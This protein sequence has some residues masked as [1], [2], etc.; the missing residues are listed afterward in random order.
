MTKI[1]YHLDEI[2]RLNRVGISMKS[3][4]ARYG[5][6]QTTIVEAL[7]DIGHAPLDTRR[8]FMEDI[9]VSLSDAEKE[10]LQ[11]MLDL[12]GGNI[13]SYIKTLISREFAQRRKK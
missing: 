1:R 8:S 12:H 2:V 11:R 6:H 10:H 4:A 13:R 7:K 3:I 5:C 9:Y